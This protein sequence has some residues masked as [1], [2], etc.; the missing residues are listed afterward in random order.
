MARYVCSVGGDVHD[1]AG[2]KV[3]H[4]IAAVR[5]CSTRRDM[6][7]MQTLFYRSV[8]KGALR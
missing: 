8:M 1:D 5:V 4:K 2:D 6:H 7:S 3:T